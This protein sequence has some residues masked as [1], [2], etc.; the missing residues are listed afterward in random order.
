L[1]GRDRGDLRRMAP[2]LLMAQDV[3]A[4]NG[5]RGLAD[6][7]QK[8]LERSKRPWIAKASPATRGRSR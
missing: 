6:E 8:A 4:E 1:T 7:A 2:A 5:L 3:F